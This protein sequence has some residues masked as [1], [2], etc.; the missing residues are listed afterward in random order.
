MLAY[1][2]NYTVDWVST[3]YKC[4]SKNRAGLKK[5]LGV[6]VP[7]P[8]SKGPPQAK[9]SHIFITFYELFIIEITINKIM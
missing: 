7:G 4:R 8:L 6:T 9:K 3:C 2:L 1:I 5:A